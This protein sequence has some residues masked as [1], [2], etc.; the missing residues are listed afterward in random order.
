[1][2]F[3]KRLIQAY[4]D[5]NSEFYIDMTESDGVFNVYK[6]TN[7]PEIAVFMN[8]PE[9]LATITVELDEKDADGNTLFLSSERL[10][11]WEE[12]DE[13]VP[14]WPQTLRT[15]E[16]MYRHKVQDMTEDYLRGTNEE[17]E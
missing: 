14:Y 5:R 13:Y 16:T 3:I 12:L 7:Y 10:E 11:D 2:K 15:L 4:R 8:V 9:N 17:D 1:M 6:F